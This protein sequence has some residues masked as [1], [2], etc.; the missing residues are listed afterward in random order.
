MYL[1]DGKSSMQMESCVAYRALRGG[2]TLSRSVPDD[3][4]ALMMDDEA[5]EQLLEASSSSAYQRPQWHCKFR[6]A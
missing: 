2:G 6:H 3:V 4:G 5:L 1:I